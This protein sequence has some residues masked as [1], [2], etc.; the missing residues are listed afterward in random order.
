MATGHSLG[1]DDRMAV[2]TLQAR[3]NPLEEEK[4]VVEVL[5]VARV[6]VT[7]VVVIKAWFAIAF[8]TEMVAAAAAAVKAFIKIVSFCA[9]IIVIVLDD[10]LK[11]NNGQTHIKHSVVK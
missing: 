6:I 7:V 10:W 8:V 11:T 9:T 3:R 1:T 5:V 4:G 2:P